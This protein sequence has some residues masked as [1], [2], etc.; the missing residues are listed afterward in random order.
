MTYSILNII[1]LVTSVILK[2]DRLADDK[3]QEDERKFEY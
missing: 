2:E 1:T 3:V